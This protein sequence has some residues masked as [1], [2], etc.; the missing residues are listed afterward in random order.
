MVP[1]VV[2]LTVFE[3]VQ[4]CSIIIP[5]FHNNV[6]SFMRIFV[7]ILFWDTLICSLVC[8]TSSRFK[9]R[10]MVW[11]MDIGRVSVRIRI[12]I[13]V[14][15]FAYLSRSHPRCNIDVGIE[16]RIDTDIRVDIDMDNGHK[17]MPSPFEET[18]CICIDL[19]PLPMFVARYSPSAWKVMSSKL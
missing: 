17:C 5:I 2:V 16:L 11:R 10:F 19:W 1:S 8:A 4:N 7:D 9:M 6:R 12:R 18:S 14:R 3:A 15:V 13:R